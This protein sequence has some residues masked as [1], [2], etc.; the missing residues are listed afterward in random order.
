M[1]VSEIGKGVP[2]FQEMVSNAVNPEPAVRGIVRTCPRGT[3]VKVRV[4]VGTI[5]L[6]KTSVGV[7]PNPGVP[8]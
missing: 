2:P 1:L 5:E 7:V 3:A 4:S 8:L 6:K